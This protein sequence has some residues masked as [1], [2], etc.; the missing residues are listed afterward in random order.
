MEKIYRNE[1]LIQIYS[2]MVK[3]RK[4]EEK[5]RDI[6]L[7]DKKPL[8]NIAAG[9]IPGE[10]HLSAGQEPSA[11]WMS[12][13]LRNDDFVYS[14]HRPHH[15]AISKG[16]DLNR[17]TAEIM[18]KHEGLSKGKGGHMHIFDKKVNF[19][20]AGIVG[21][22]FPPAI[23]AALAFKLDKKDSIA[24][25]FG[26]D[27]SLNQGMFLE[28]LNLAALWKLPV[29]F[30][31]ENNDWAI[32]V[33]T[34]DSTPLKNDA[35]RASGFGIPGIYIKGNDPI[36]MYEAAAG[37]VKRA[38]SGN[39]P[40][41]I[42]IDT[43]RYYGHFE[44]DP[45]IYRPKDRVKKLLEK[46]PIKR[47]EA[48]LVKDNIMTED[49]N[50]RILNSA[51]EEVSQA[52]AFAENC[53][54]PIGSD[55]IG[56]VYAPVD[57]DIKPHTNGRKIPVYMAISEGISQEMERNENVLYMGE[58]V[59]KYGGIFGATT[60]LLAKFG[61][62]RIRDTP[63]SESAFI[64]SAAG[65]A[66]AGKRPIVELMFSD[67]IGVC[68]DP[69]MNQIA[70]NY[71]MSGGTVNMP[72]VITT[73]VGGGYG[74][75]A[76]HSQ[77]LYSLFGHLPGL[78]VVVPSNS[79][80]AK[81]LMISAIMDNNP[82]IYMF[83]KG[84]LGLPWMPYPQST[85]MEVPEEEYTVPIGKAK[86]VREGKD[87]TIVGLGATVHMAME[88][89]ANLEDKGINA[90]VV[91]LRSIKPLDTDTVV[92]SV[93]KTGSLLVVD[94]DYISFGMASEIIAAVTE[95]SFKMLK[96]APGRI[97]I[98]DAPIPYSQPMEKFVLPDSKKI[99]DYAIEMLM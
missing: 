18:G 88:A 68:L 20:C 43:Y 85:I 15:T 1:D 74:D 4:Y 14:T 56:D 79:F 31:I 34:K 25:A 52:F 90:E 95:K 37:A 59:G 49:E 75:A 5:L 10:M 8:F 89:A 93:N 69:I 83:H 46:D 70:K 19:A 26:G 78:K 84:L 92:Q 99:F 28:S 63:I 80:D 58:D 86:V 39:G 30:V 11:A 57:Y 48:K 87:I 94:E 16:V 44:G 91:D 81:G 17:M 41:L 40:T 61:P 22:S 7:A 77:T 82:V 6:Y 67:F 65:L 42:S 53:S 66:A 35:I 73:A 51:A 72:V 29:I 24:V 45:Q 13:L 38:R 12:A 55:A 32:S 76:Q 96:H 2:T 50:E 33:E 3:S 97:A 98:Q 64:G 62:E 9:K 47:L 36:K 23:G 71:Y 21:S 54:L 60:G 27:G